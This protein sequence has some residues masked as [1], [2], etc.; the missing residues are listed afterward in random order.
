MHRCIDF[1]KTV[2]ESIR[3]YTIMVIN[4]RKKKVKL[5]TKKQQLY[6]N[7]KVSFIC[8]KSF[9]KNM[10]KI[11]TIQKLEAIAIIGVSMEVLPI[12]CSY[13]NLGYLNKFF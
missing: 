2:C 5:L 3:D 1:M 9:N 10:L 7:E 13:E 8:K 12:A 11:K 6:Q 4:F